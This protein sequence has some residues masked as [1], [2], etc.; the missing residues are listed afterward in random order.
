MRSDVPVGLFLSSGIDSGALLAIMSQYAS[1]PVHTFTI[2][3]E[4]GEKSNETDEARVMANRFGAD[5][6]EMIIGP[7]DYERYYERYMG[8]L[9]EPVGN[10]TAAAFYFVSLIA[11]QKVKVALSGQG[12][13][14]PWA[15]YNR[16]IGIKFSASYSQLPT[17][18]TN[19]VVHGAVERFA[20]NAVLKRGA[21]SLSEPDV[22]TRFVKVYSFFTESMK[23]KLFRP[24]VKEYISSDGREARHALKRLQADVNGLDPLTQMLYIDTRA[25]LPDD[26]LMVADKTAMANSLEARV[27]FLDH[28]LVEFIETLPPTLK[29]RGFQGK[30]LHKKALTKWLP[31]EVVYRKKKG[32][33]NPIDKW[34]RVKMRRYVDNCL[35]SD[36]S[37]VNRYFERSYI[38][39]LLRAHESN[40]Q[41]YLRHI[42]LL[43]SF[44]LWH[45]RF[46]NN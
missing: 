10:E 26:L 8:D 43:I 35:A 3:F 19:C 13:D 9:E 7:Q 28:R 30:Y 21:A 41:E 31:N 38:Q 29:L 40:R 20:K 5:H 17:F 24:W 44:E 6:S 14:E 23:A 33:A 39:E 16:Y 1:R 11:S 4:D 18:L 25:N 34:L 22:L 27:P 45:Q 42:Y 46:L 15:G 12:A 36:H 37:A 2:G 32:F